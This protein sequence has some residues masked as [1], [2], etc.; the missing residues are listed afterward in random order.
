MYKI[1]QWIKKTFPL[2]WEII[3]WLNSWLFYVR[4]R[5]KL[6]SIDGILQRFQGEYTVREA[7][8]DDID[9]IVAFFIEQPEDAFAFFAPHSFDAK[10]VL[11]LIKRKSYLFFLV[12]KGDAIVGYFFLR[13]FAQGK[14][15]RGKIVDY[16]WRGR[17]IAKLMGLASTDVAQHLG[18]RMFGTISKENVSSMASSAA[19]NEIKI[20]EYLP[21][22]YVY[23]E[24]LPKK[25]D[26]A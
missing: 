22:D 1:A 19:V 24:Y 23:I 14:C 15:F 17:G 3:E 26:G 25:H 4:Y 12:L 13:C 2:V 10:T 6:L 9:G 16:R 20:I 7:R 18:L 21:D 8:T 5:K 11:K